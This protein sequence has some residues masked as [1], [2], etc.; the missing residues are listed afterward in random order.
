MLIT[1]PTFLI[2]NVSKNIKIMNLLNEFVRSAVRQVGRDGGKVISN[3]VYKKQHGTPIYNSSNEENVFNKEES[4]NASVIDMSI[5]KPIKGGGIGV[6]VKGLAIQIIPFGILG[7][8]YKG[9][10]YLNQKET[11]IYRKQSNKVADKRHNSGYRIDGYSIVKTNDKRELDENE[12]KLIKNRGYSYLISIL[13]FFAVA[14]LL[15]INQPI[16]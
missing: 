6:V 4:K 8:L 15:Y 16:K 7:V 3:K 10:K 14:Y 5:Q 2:L 9:I 13:I 11:Y 1:C 12:I